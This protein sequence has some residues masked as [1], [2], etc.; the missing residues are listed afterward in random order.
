MPE[1]T[2]QHCGG[3]LR[4]IG[5]D[6]FSGREMREY[7]CEKC[8][9]TITEDGGRALWEIISEANEEDRKEALAAAAKALKSGKRPWWKFWR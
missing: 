3:A 8:G 2:C 6:T 9:E 1:Q 7:E 5:K 4:F